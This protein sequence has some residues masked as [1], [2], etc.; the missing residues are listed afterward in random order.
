MNIQDIKELLKEKGF[1]EEKQDT[2]VKYSFTDGDVELI[3]YIEPDIEIEFIS[4]YRW[5]H[6]EVKGAQNISV[7]DLSRTKDSV[8]TLFKK[9]KN[10]LP[11]HI[12]EKIDT[13]TEIDRVIDNL[14]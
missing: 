6:N 4:L 10:N 2:G 3:A 13:H 5:Q 7:S 1:K 14:F 8:A 11:Q 9:T 12:G